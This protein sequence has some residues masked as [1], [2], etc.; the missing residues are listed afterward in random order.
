MGKSF[1]SKS[2]VDQLLGGISLN[3]LGGNSDI[4]ETKKIRA[5][6][7][8]VKLRKNLS[9]GVKRTYRIPRSLDRAL[10][11]RAAEQGLKKNDIFQSALTEYLNEYLQEEE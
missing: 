7:T 10:S 11:L 1:D 8:D 5:A 6:K 3:V 9:D 2:K 4:E